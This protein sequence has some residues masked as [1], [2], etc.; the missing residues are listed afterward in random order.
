M[1]PARFGALT[2][3]ER[4]QLAGED[5]TGL[6]VEFFGEISIFAKDR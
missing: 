5:S 4:L 6:E 2:F 3:F 1:E